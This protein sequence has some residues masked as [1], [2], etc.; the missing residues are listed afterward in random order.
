[1]FKIWITF[2]VSLAFGYKHSLC[3]RR[4]RFCSFFSIFFWYYP[5]FPDSFRCFPTF[6]DF[7]SEFFSRGVR[8][9]NR[10]TVN[11]E[12]IFTSLFTWFVTNVPWPQSNSIIVWQ[13]YWSALVTQKSD[14]IYLICYMKEGQRRNLFECSVSQSSCDFLPSLSF[15]FFLRVNLQQLF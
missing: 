10:R 11:T 1:M 4:V 8:L 3:Y 6:S 7:F 13:I 12:F 5:L 9:W 2:S 14:F 15:H